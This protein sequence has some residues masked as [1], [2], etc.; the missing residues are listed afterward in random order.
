M[1]IVI[2]RLGGKEIEIVI[3]VND[4]DLI[5][6]NKFI[7]HDEISIDGLYCEDVIKFATALLRAAEEIK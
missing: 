5:F 6:K 4:I 1:S 2:K 3:H 7:L